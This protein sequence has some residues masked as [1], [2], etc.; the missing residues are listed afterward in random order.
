MSEPVQSQTAPGC[1]EA[2]RREDG[3][4]TLMYRPAIIRVSGR[5]TVCLVRNIS[6][7]GL[8]CRVFAN[9]A[10]GE[11][12]TVQITEEQDISG[13][14][15]WATE[16]RIGI[17]AVDVIDVSS[18][19]VLLGDTGKRHRPRRPLR[20]AASAPVKIRLFERTLTGQLVDISQSGAKLSVSGLAASDR[21][22]VAL[23]D[24]EEKAGV[25]RWIGEGVCGLSFLRPLGFEELARWIADHP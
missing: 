17:R 8:M 18:L 22:H 14:V 13:E 25:V 15:V 10:V 4:L 9:F 6:T 21:V 3:R 20:L 16:D 11:T 5:A 7:S 19:L 12:V 1:D 23:P 24:I 2:E